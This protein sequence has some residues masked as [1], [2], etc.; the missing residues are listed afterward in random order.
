MGDLNVSMLAEATGAPVVEAPKTLHEV[1]KEVLTSHPYNRAVLSLYQP[2]SLF[3]GLSAVNDGQGHL[4]WTYT[5]LDQSAERLARSLHTQGLRSGMRLAVFLLNGAEWALLFWASVKLNAT[6]VALDE[7]VVPR[8]EEVD[9]YLSVTKP[10]A[11]FVS[12]NASARTLLKSNYDKVDAIAIK[13]I[14]APTEGPQ[15]GWY[16]LKDFV[17]E[18]PV[19]NGSDSLSERKS[20]RATP[21]FRPPEVAPSISFS[22]I[23]YESE[24]SIDSVVYIT[25]TSGSAGIP[26]S[27]SRH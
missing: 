7:G 24:H 9:H 2:E 5:E 6:F 18:V 21:E 8:S 20:H 17:D 15:E 13:A 25:F 26:Q 1:F 4:N 3:T 23:G 27:M 12:S 19:V 14:T 16:C 11:V 10:S 22:T